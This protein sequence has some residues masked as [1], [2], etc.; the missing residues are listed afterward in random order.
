MGKQRN[1]SRGLNSPEFL[2]IPLKRALLHPECIQ[3]IVLAMA[4]NILI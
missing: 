1:L 2:L 4:A 3:C